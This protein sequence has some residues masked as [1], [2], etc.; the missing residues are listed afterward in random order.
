M[1]DKDEISSPEE[2]GTTPV[3]KSQIFY[4]CFKCVETTNYN[5][6]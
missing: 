4:R 2:I 1:G 5:I 6:I 3:I